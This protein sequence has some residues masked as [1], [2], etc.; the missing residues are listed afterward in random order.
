M[1]HEITLTREFSSLCVCTKLYL[2]VNT[3]MVG[4]FDDTEAGKKE[5]QTAYNH[6]VEQV[7][8]YGMI[9]EPI[10]KEVIETEDK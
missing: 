10:L 9:N 2:R 4:N 1:K 7:R 5:A 6:A 8:K 3:A